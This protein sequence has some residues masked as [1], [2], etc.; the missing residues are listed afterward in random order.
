MA[1][2]PTPPPSPLVPG[3]DRLPAAVGTQPGFLEAMLRRISARSELAGLTTR[4]A[5]DPSIGLLD[6]AAT[7]LDVLAFYGDLITNEGF[8]RTATERRSIAELARGIGYELAPGVAATTVL[9]FS[10][11][12][13]P[14]AHP[15]VR[16]P[17]GLPAQK[18]PGED[19]VVAVYET[20]TDV[21][22]RKE[23]NELRL[24]RVE[25]V[26]PRFGDDE[27]VLAGTG[28]GVA[29]GDAVLLVGEERMADPGREEW[30]VRRVVEVDEVPAEVGLDADGAPARTV[31][32]LDAPIGH[33]DPHV[34]PASVQPRCY[35]FS[36]SGTLF[37]A[38]APR[39]AELP[40]NLRIGEINPDPAAS[41]AFIP[42]PF[43]GK[44][45]QWVDAN[46]A[47]TTTELWLDRIHT[48]VTAGSWIVLTRPG[49]SELYGVTASEHGNRNAFLLSG[50]STKV[51]VSGENIDRFSI[52]STA[53]LTGS[54]ELPLGTR[55]VAGPVTGT[56]V[57]VDTLVELER[58]RLVVVTGFDAVTGEPV[59]EELRVYDAVPD[60]T[61]SLPGTAVTF[62]T[63]LT[64]AYRPSGFRIRGNCAPATH[65]QTVRSHPLASGDA[66]RSFTTVPL[67]VSEDG[68]LTYTSAD[69]PSGRSSSLE[70]RVDGVRW[71][72]VGSF[73]GQPPDAQVYVVRHGERS[74]ATVQFGDGTTGSR[75]G[76]G[77]DNVTATFRVG[78]GSAGAAAR[79]QISLPLGMP[80]GLRDVVNPVPAIGGEDPETIDQ[81]R[82]NA[83]TTVRTL[84]RVVS[85]ADHED[86]ARAF[87]GIGWASAS[88]VDDGG[89]AVVHVTA[90]LLDGTPL[91]AGSDLERKLVAAIGRARH[92]DRPLVVAGHVPRPIEVR[93]R[94]RLDDR[95][96]GDDVLAAARAAVVAVFDRSPSLGDGGG[97]G[98]LVTPTRVLAALQRTAGVLGAVLDVLRPVG[99]VGD[100][101]VEVLARPARLE[102]GAVVAAELLEPIVVEITEVSP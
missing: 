70:V 4:E 52:R 89:R 54:R 29:V 3:L 79:G 88:A 75:P 69:T 41:K 94:L 11:D 17:A 19:Q 57:T 91:P 73:A 87:A 21:L 37:G 34:E 56:T 85:L 68:P 26:V 99:A 10:I 14:G 35:A 36:S 24:R 20:S 7:M 47:S 39:H 43:A 51:T 48:E 86:F 65:G 71:S 95:H 46:L 27:L 66:S 50:P 77:R 61:S 90:T 15:V 74:S 13:P 59:S 67:S 25:P 6:A 58:G 5:D 80:L 2:R 53:V 55:P 8:V 40:V 12:P 18:L 102:G 23:L 42:G 81:A 31:L 72:E 100:A 78:V 84:D 28:H 62:T 9:A 38:N 1:H 64:H 32:T 22:A 60:G 45:G 33:L 83:P 63:A 49:Y 98:K 93:A 97:F 30:D 101:V 96:V 76:S 44:A 82:V 92:V 16:I